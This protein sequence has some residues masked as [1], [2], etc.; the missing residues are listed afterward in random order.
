MTVKPIKPKAIKPKAIKP[1]KTLLDLLIKNSEVIQPF[2]P[3]KD[4]VKGLAVLNGVYLI[5]TLMDN[6][7]N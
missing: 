1:I 4:Y 2:V 7:S 6:H 5:L 3:P